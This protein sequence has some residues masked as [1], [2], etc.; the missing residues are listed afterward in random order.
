MSGHVESLKFQD[1]LTIAGVA[2]A[3]FGSE[4][5]HRRLRLARLRPWQRHSRL[6][7]ASTMLAFNAVLAHLLDTILKSS[8][9]LR[10]QHD[11]IK[12]P[13]SLDPMT[14]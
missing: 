8:F 2:G 1:S 14:R 9:K 4:A 13:R 11:Q 5:P 7:S 6:A 10:L 3:R 12:F